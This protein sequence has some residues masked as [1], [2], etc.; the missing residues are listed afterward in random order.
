MELNLMNNG[1]TNPPTLKGFIQKWV[2]VSTN[3]HY[4]LHFVL[5]K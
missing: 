5:G 1:S 4:P 2:V 3:Y